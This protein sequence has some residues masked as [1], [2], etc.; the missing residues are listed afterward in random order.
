MQKI[1]KNR[2][3]PKE[4]SFS[5]LQSAIHNEFSSQSSREEEKVKSRKEE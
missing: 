4:A 2:K 5:E 3:N 1:S